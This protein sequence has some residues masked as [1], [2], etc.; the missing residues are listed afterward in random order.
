MDKDIME[1]LSDFKFD[2]PKAINSLRHFLNNLVGVCR[3][4]FY[5]DSAISSKVATWVDHLDEKEMQYK[6][7]DLP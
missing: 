2:Y 6:M 1:K 5:G 3:L 7:N 4:L